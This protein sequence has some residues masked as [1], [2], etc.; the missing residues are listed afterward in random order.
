MS[1]ETIVRNNQ[2]LKKNGLLLLQLLE[3]IEIYFQEKFIIEDIIFLA[4]PPRSGT[5]WLM[6]ILETIPEYKT[7][8]EPLNKKY[9]PEN[10]TLWKNQPYLYFDVQ[11][12]VIKNQ[13][14]QLFLGTKASKI[15]Y[16]DSYSPLDYISRLKKKKLII[17]SI[18][19]C[20]LVP[21]LSN[22]FNFR[23]MFI[24]IRHPCATIRSQVENK[25]GWFFTPDYKEDINVLKLKLLEDIEN[26]SELDNKEF[27]FNK[28][29]KINS[30]KEIIAVSWCLDVYLP[31]KY[32][33]KKSWNI[34]SYEQLF[35]NPMEKVEKIFSILDEKP[36]EKVYEKI[37]KVTRTGQFIQSKNKFD[38]KIQLS[39]WKEKL[40]ENDISKIMTIV[41]DW[42]GLDLYND[43]FPS[44]ESLRYFI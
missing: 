14:N 5:T 8:F 21:W 39:K 20:R 30:I 42:F 32:F 24:I 40:N 43:F 38:P 11:N 22:A 28:I 41:Q 26:I 3:N 19:G 16:H 1:V 27:L 23:E 10:L 44:E 2:L 18:E 7:I 36:N 6:N 9:Y 17:K 15:P 13:L 34:I 25:I 37:N 4:G 12:E 35:L 31:I 29:K 33:N